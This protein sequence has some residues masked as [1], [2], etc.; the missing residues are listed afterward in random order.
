M[1]D[2][3]TMEYEVVDAYNRDD[4]NKAL[5]EKIKEKWLP[6]ANHVITF[7]P[8]FRHDGISDDYHMHHSVMMCRSTKVEGKK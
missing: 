3:Y 7:V 2:T 5:A 6:T 8:I 1:A 4:F